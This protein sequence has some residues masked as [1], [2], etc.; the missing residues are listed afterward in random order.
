MAMG[1][2]GLSRA[3]V[4]KVVEK[5]FALGLGFVVIFLTVQ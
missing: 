2:P 4:P 5:F 1:N 3:A